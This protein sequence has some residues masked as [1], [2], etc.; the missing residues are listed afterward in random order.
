MADVIKDTIDAL[1]LKDLEDITNPAPEGVPPILTA[2]KVLSVVTKLREIE[3]H[4]GYY[5]I[6]M[7]ENVW[8]SQVK[9]IEAARVAKIVELSP[10]EVIP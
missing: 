7:L 8:Y 3:K 10:Q 1:L 9:E 4:N 5:G 6:S 2:A